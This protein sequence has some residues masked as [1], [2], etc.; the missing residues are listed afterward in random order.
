MKNK[1]L[2]C[3]GRRSHF[4]LLLLFSLICG[5]N[6]MN[7]Q[8]VQVKGVVTDDAGAIPGVTVQVQGKS[9]GTITDIDGKYLIA[10]EKGEV[11]VFSFIGME[12]A[13]VTVKGALHNVQMKSDA[14]GLEEVVAIGYGT[15]KKKELT[16]AVAQVKAD[17]ISRLVTADVGSALQGLVAGVNVTNS[18]SP[19]ESASIL[20]RGITSIDGNNTPL[21]V[22]DGIPQEGDPRLSPNEIQTLDILKDAAS[23]AIYGTRGAA[24]VILITTKQGKAG[25]LRVSVDA[26][27]GIQNITSSTS[28]MTAEEQ[29]YS[30]FLYHEHSGSNFDDMNLRYLRS[31][32]SFQNNS[33]LREVIFVDYAPVQSYNA[34]ISGGTKDITYSL[35]AGYYDQ[36][37]IIINSDFERFNMR[38][39]TT[40]KHGKWKINGT[41][42]LIHEDRSQTPS[43]IIT[44]TIKYQPTMPML[45]PFSDEGYVSSGEGGSNESTNAGWVME[46]LKNTDESNRNTSF[47]SLNLNYD[48]IKGLSFNTRVGVRASN[49]Y[50]KRFDP[51]TEIVDSEGELIND[52]IKDSGIQMDASTNTSFTWD[53]SLTYRKTFA[54]KHNLTAVLAQSLERYDYDSFWASR[55][56]VDNNNIQVLNGALENQANGSGS[57]YV[58][59]LVGSLARMQYAYKGKYL[60]SASVR[61]DGSSKFAEGNRWGVFPS[62]SAAW[63]V[64]DE[65]FWDG[66]EDKVNNLKLRASY[67]TVGN[68]SFPAYRYSTGIVNGI[69]YA[70]A[71]G[72]TQQ[73]LNIDYGA[74][75]TGYANSE[76]KWE[77]SIQSNLGIDLGL[78]SNKLTLT[79]EYYNTKKE[80]MLMPVRVPSSNGSMPNM[81]TD[82]TTYSTVYLNVGNMTNKGLE[83]AASYKFKTGKVNWSTSGTFSTN[84]NV[85]TQINEG[86]GDD[87]IL[88]DNSGLVNGRKSTSQVTALAKGYEAGAFFIF[89]TDGIANTEAL[90]AEYQELDPT[91]R[92][93]DVMYVD[94]DGDGQVRNSGDRVY[95]GSGLAEYEVGLNLSAN[96]KNFDF[97]MR[98]YSAIGHE[99]MNGSKATAYSWGRHADLAY[100]YSPANPTSNI[101]AYR[102]EPS[103]NANYNGYT[104]L[105][106]EDGTFLRL[107]ELT[108]GYTLPKVTLKKLNIDKLRFYVSAQN[109]LTFTAYEGYD[110]EVGGSLSSKGLDK[111]NYPIASIYTFGVNLKF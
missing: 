68:Q 19:G 22:V 14:I 94:H 105:W 65:P 79:A 3:L 67:G 75:M 20:I 48:I 10:A 12:K 47:G 58:N 93:G 41:V 32:S 80:G 51:F 57:N 1:S 40:Y 38:A 59:K 36:N 9:G 87:Y 50:R 89:E 62:A 18:G 6:T 95:G 8:T 82:Y 109:P 2:K 111:G 70:F 110:P 39:N 56:Y 27:Y 77:T 84:N 23:C 49:L 24:G 53:A 54:K 99:V 25:S 76:V 104:D 13:F 61:R 7:A 11:L 31:T 33:D 97:S 29:S 106:L 102:G 43:Y 103:Q 91:A 42:G 37:G 92:L 45:D 34:M 63:N 46:T 16:G 69:D 35:S 96:Y 21:Y 88:L 52:P 66:L 17:Q 90:L 55:D 86:S 78:F 60:F 26:S 107:K 72:T 71:S 100:Q 83:F 5:L 73:S 30:E 81:T 44:Q 28:L 15:V 108:L 4:W 85:V 101:P 74:A 64:S 98:W